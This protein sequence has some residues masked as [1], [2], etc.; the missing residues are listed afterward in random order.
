MATRRI[1]RELVD[2]GKKELPKKLAFLL[3]DN[4]DFLAVT[5]YEDEDAWTVEI[6]AAALQSLVRKKIELKVLKAGQ[7]DLASQAALVPQMQKELEKLQARQEKSAAKEGELRKALRQ[8]KAQER[9]SPATPA[10]SP[11]DSK[12]A[13][14]VKASNIAKAPSIASQRIGKSANSSAGTSE[15]GTP[16]KLA[17]L[18]AKAMHATTAVESA[19][20]ARQ[21]AVPT[22]MVT[23]DTPAAVAENLEPRSKLRVPKTAISLAVEV[24]EEHS[25]QPG[26]LPG[27][28]PTASA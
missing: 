17:N 22:S 6:S 13:K 18:P 16:A 5:H 4:V 12:P 26:L 8:A 9:Q 24:L 21:P 10:S 20:L 11:T 2:S 3:R 27:A 14:A 19:T 15:V 28:S 1:K 7:K 25:P 23:D